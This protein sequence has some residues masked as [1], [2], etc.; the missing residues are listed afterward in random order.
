VKAKKVLGLSQVTQNVY[1]R[2]T[3][4][5]SLGIERYDHEKLQQV[6]AAATSSISS[7]YFK[8]QQ[9]RLQVLCIFEEAAATSYISSGVFMHQQRR[10]S[11]LL[12]KR[13][14]TTKIPE[15]W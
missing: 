3:V 14:E 12:F 6:S 7:S 5:V 13:S 2:D 10:L 9:Q 1:R 4:T 15:S 11:D 8:Y